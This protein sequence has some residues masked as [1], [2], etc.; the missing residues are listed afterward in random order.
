[1]PNAFRWKCQRCGKREA[2]LIRCPNCYYGICADCRQQLRE[3]ACDSSC[4][5]CGMDPSAG[6]RVLVIDDD[7]D[8]VDATVFIDRIVPNTVGGVVDPEDPTVMCVGGLDTIN[9]DPDPYE[10]VF[11]DVDPG[12]PVC[13]DIYPKQ[14]DTVPATALPQ[15]YIAFIDVIG[16]SVTT[17]DTREV[18][19]L[20]PPSAP[21]E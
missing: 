12:T 14:N 15:L 17:L 13:F 21:I 19:F 1:M 6:K 2:D 16:D 8:A 18:Y 5:S 3:E 10:D 9:S 7:P 20:I 4:P 11:D